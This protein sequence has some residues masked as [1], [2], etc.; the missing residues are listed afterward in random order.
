MRA[1]FNYRIHYSLP[2][3]DTDS[4]E[5]HTDT[6]EELREQAK[7]GVAKRN[8]TDPWSEAI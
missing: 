2:N 6:L 3:G 4:F 5:L 8:G 7:S 1:H